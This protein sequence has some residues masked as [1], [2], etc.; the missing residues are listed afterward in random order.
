MLHQ[1]GDD[2]V[3]EEG[4]S[5]L[6]PLLSVDLLVAARTLELQMCATW[7]P[8]SYRLPF[9]TEPI[10]IAFPPLTAS[11]DFFEKHTKY[12]IRAGTYTPS[13][14]SLAP[15]HTAPHHVVP[16]SSLPEPGVL[17]KKHDWED[18]VHSCSSFNN[19]HLGPCLILLHLH[20]HLGFCIVSFSCGRRRL[21]D[22]AT[23]AGTGD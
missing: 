1:E 12:A 6:S 21:D 22:H 9:A 14:T 10:P 16:I 18:D 11:D 13:D 2:A 3:A 17:N 15:H 4:R 7:H 5:A 20:S 23:L 8:D 19:Q